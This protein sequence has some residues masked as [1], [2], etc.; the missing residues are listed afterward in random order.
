DAIRDVAVAAGDY[1]ITEASAGATRVH[2]AV[3]RTGVRASAQDWVAEVQK[4]LARL[5]DLLGPHPYP[6]LWLTI[7][8]TQSDGVEFPTHLQFG[9]VGART[10]PSLVAHELAHSWFYSLVG[11]NQARDPWL[12]ESFA[13]WAQAIAAGQQDLYRIR[14]FGPG[15][16]A[17]PIG[18]PMSFWDANGGFRALTDGVYDQGAA[19]LLD[20]RERVGADRFDAAMRAYVATNAHRVVTPADVEAAFRDLPEVLDVLRSHGAFRNP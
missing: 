2:V 5:E 19:A 15:E 7:V 14:N 8:P 4:Q 1:A 12:D 17:G 16:V 20:G 18:A 9:D 10:R 11:N 6:D 13:T 3:P